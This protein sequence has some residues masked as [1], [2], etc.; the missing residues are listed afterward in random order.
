MSAPPFFIACITLIIVSFFSDHSR[1][2]SPFILSSLLIVVVGLV[3]VITIPLHNIPGRYIGLI[4][5][6]SSTLIPSP[7]TVAWLAGNTPEPGKRTLVLGV[8]GWGNVG[9]IIGSEIFLPQYGPDYRWPLRVTLGLVA[10][11]FVGYSICVLAFVFVNRW[12]RKMLRGMTIEELEEE[13]SIGDGE[14]Y[15]DKKLTF[16]YGL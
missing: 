14:R 1:H 3:M 2:R 6:L 5:L 4:I 8:N 11:S 10:V 7:I 13:D 12:K 16:I 15:A 9:G